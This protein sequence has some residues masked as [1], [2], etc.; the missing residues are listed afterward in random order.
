MAPVEKEEPACLLEEPSLLYHLLRLQ[1]HLLR[2]QAQLSR[3]AVSG[4]AVL[5][6]KA[7]AEHLLG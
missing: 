2:L 1:A 4:L 3:L 5:A 7:L 6:A